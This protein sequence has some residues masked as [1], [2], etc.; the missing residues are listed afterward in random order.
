MGF[1]LLA[2]SLTEEKCWGGRKGMGVLALM[3]LGGS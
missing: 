1:R 2:G 3:L